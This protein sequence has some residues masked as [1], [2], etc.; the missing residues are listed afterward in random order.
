MNARDEHESNVCEVPAERSIASERAEARLEHL[1]AETHRE[2][3]RFWNLQRP[4][5]LFVGRRRL[6]L[7]IAVA[8]LAGGGAAV[9]VTISDGVHPDRYAADARP[10]SRDEFMGS[11]PE[12]VLK[13]ITN[14]YGGDAIAEAEIAGPP[15]DFEP[16]DGTVAPPDGFEDS[17]WAYITVEAPADSPAAI[18]A[19]WEADLVS[20]VL[21]DGMHANGDRL[22]ATRISLRLPDGT[23]LP[24]VAGGLGEVSLN[25]QFDSPRTSDIPEE[26]GELAAAAGLTV[27][28][29]EILHADQPAPAVVAT[30]SD[31]NAVADN[32]GAI[33]NSIFGKPPKYEGYY[34]EIRNGRGEPIVI[35]AADFR[36]GAGH[37]WI[38]PEVSEGR[39]SE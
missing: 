17:L 35:Q 11:T 27:E 4:R 12:Q 33:T 23:E 14:R 26:I 15:T 2:R 18:R 8:L 25:Q 13:I 38:H 31:P 16:T 34:L 9:A 6:A 10:R 21:R 30:T 36:T 28:S 29:I 3:R 24:N 1:L 37:Q 32:L 19:I 20:G 7:A 39:G 22:Y 5:S